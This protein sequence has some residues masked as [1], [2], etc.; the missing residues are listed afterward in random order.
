M[1]ATLG[2]RQRF[3]GRRVLLASLAGSFAG[4][5]LLAIAVNSAPSSSSDGPFDGFVLLWLVSVPF[6]LLVTSLVELASRIFRPTRTRLALAGAL[7]SAIMISL[8][9]WPP[10]LRGN[11]RLEEDPRHWSVL[12]FAMVT[13]VAWWGLLPTQESKLRKEDQ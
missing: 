2:E 3:G 11:P 12:V 1:T 8:P 7:L 9:F 5:L 13:A 4:A 6:V 10:E